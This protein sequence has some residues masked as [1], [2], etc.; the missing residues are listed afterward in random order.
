MGFDRKLKYDLQSCPSALGFRVPAEWEPH[1]ATWL[2]WPH[3]FETWPEELPQIEAIYCEIIEHLCSGEKVHVLVEDEQMKDSVF[4]KLRAKG[5]T[6]NVFLHQIETDSI[7]IRDYGPMFLVRRLGKSAFLNFKFNAWGRKYDAFEKDDQV[8]NRL[9]S[10]L[11]A[12]E[13]RAELVL[14]G[15][16]I[17]V[18][19]MGTCLTTEECVLNPNRN[20]S[21]TRQEM[22]QCLRDFVGV[23]QVIWL[24]AGLAGDDTD[25]HID[26]V[27]RFVAPTT[28]VAALEWN[29]HSQ[30]FGSLKKNWEQLCKSVDQDGKRFNIITLPMPETVAL[31]G[32]QL[33]ASYANF[34]IGN[35]VVLVPV[36]NRRSDRTALGILKDLFPSRN[37]VGINSIPLII[38]LGAIHC[39]TQ[40]QPAP[41]V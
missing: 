27:A 28:V 24:E 8:P 14:E 34:Y 23:R 32:I 26:E 25:G 38:G 21:L 17:D 10:I 31:N 20:T 15:G 3:D 18:N 9:T 11:D 4:Q 2:A 36:F 40:Q 5:I 16:A 22:E 12:Q 13:F 19:G 30:D 1:E 41:L 37:V 33:P 35:K 7:W 29:T 39:I 6:K